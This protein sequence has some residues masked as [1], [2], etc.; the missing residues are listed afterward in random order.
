V[1]YSGYAGLAPPPP[2]TPAAPRRGQR[3]VPLRRRETYL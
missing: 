1:L 2:G 3:W